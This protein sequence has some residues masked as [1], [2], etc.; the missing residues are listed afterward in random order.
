[1]L[2][3]KRYHHFDNANHILQKK[4]IQYIFLSE[5]ENL[6]EE[7]PLKGNEQ[8][9]QR[10]SGKEDYLNREQL[11]FTPPRRQRRGGGVR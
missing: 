5:K 7:M 3:Q 4:K 9:Y 2:S 10:H 6:L 8:W 11:W 1:M